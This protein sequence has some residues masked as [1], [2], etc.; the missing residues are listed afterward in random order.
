MT[1]PPVC[2]LYTQDPDLVRRVK[3]YLRTMAEVRHV[4][5]G[6]RL[7]AVLQQSR[8]ALCITD[9]RGKES[10]DLLE[11]IRTEWPDILLIA[12][13]TVRSEPLLD[14]E[15]SGIYA[16]EDLQL[17]RQRFQALVARA[18][19][20]LKVLQENREL[21]ETRSIITIAPVSPPRTE[22]SAERGSAPSLRLLR[23][24]R[25]FRRFE[26]VDSLLENLVESIA[27]AA[28]V[29]RVGIFSKIRQGDRYRLRA[30]L[31]CIPETHE[32]EFGDRD[33][34]VRWFEMQAHLISRAGLA[35][36]SEQ[37]ER[38]LLRRAL[39][40]FG[41]EVIVPLHGRGRIIGWIFF[42][43]R[44]TGQPFEYA[45]LESLMLLAEHVSTVLENALLHE[46]TTLQKTLAETLLKSIPPGIV[47]MDEEGI[48]RWFNPT[49]EQILG[50]PAKTVL[51]K[52]A[53]AAGGT[54]AAF[55]RDALDTTANL[56]ARQW[57]DNNTRRS[58]LVETRRLLDGDTPLG[59][60]AVVQDLTAEESLREKQGLLD[61]AAFWTDLAASM[62]HEIR[63]PLV[64]IKTFAQLLPER[65]D[66][67]DF[68]K[69]FNEIV[70]GEVDRLDRIVTQIS[71]FA[72]PPELILKPIDVRSSVR[73]GIEIARSRFGVN[74]GVAVETMLPN[75][76]PKVLGDE[77]ALA[78]AFA[79]LVANAAEAAS[80][81][82]KP[83]ITLVAKPLQHGKQGGGV[84]VTVRDNG[85]G[86][87]PD[88]RDK[89]F[90]PF[91]TTKPRG[92][93][94]G[95][96]I[97]KRTVFDHNGRVDIDSST[98]GTLVSVALPASS[99]KK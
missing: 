23:F 63:N 85:K 77:T 5:D 40:T 20:Y 52:P 62:S 53:E 71:D 96:P 70:V 45:D 51:N 3:A 17:D 88:L 66:D 41:A 81:Q 30:G 76:L 56:P 31:R 7:N 28:G 13:G 22:P 57:I 44:L 19:D 73:K 84:V 39:D 50:L 6:D 59:A 4:S 89:V 21:H 80:G 48:I 1:S 35:Q 78:E 55:L 27:D 34:L 10:R 14:A 69:E 12:L 43:H 18:F 68:R 93:G 11:Q 46:E 97:V 87:A 37:G 24:P 67:A 83:Q 60:V 79:H 36:I 90:S 58:I 75:D 65:F 47:A 16:A 64:A 26:N 29:S 38:A 98:R 8:P 94:L 9:L 61:R 54:L 95:L 99:P 92:M 86:I 25:V 42:G 74:G 15:Q 72:H 49:A 91:C 82:N 2:I 33:A 32:V